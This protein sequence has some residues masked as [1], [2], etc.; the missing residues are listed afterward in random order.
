MYCRLRHRRCIVIRRI[1]DVMLLNPELDPRDDIFGKIFT[2]IRRMLSCI[3]NKTSQKVPKNSV[4]S[5]IVSQLRNIFIF[6]RF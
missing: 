3:G 5:S 2:F 6:T 1:G 4:L